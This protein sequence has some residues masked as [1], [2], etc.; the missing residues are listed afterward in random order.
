M[1]LEQILNILGTARDTGTVFPYPL[2][3]GEQEVG[4][5][6]VLEQQVDLVDEHPGALAQLAVPNDAVENTVEDYQHPNGKELLA[7][8]PDVVAD[9]PGAG[10]HIGGFGEGVQA[11]L[12]EQL[13]GQCHIVGLLLGLFQQLRMEILKGRSL[14][15]TVALK[16]IA[17]DRCGTA[18][19]ERLLPGGQ[20]TAAH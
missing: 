9:Q 17:V 16:I 12:R 7:Q 15:G 8:V 20:L 2:P 1:G 10:I 6:L 5:I 11:A 18:V 4:R 19:D 13:D 14:S 3:E